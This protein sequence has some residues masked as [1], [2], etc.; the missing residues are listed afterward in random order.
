M[1][2]KRRVKEANTL[3]AHLQGVVYLAFAEYILHGTIDQH[4]TT[5]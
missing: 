5:V 4:G 3:L 2:F 1:T